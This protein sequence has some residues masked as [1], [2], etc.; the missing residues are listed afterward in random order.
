MFRTLTHLALA[1]ALIALTTLQALPLQ[2]QEAVFQ[3]IRLTETQITNYLK[4]QNELEKQLEKIE[5]A[6]RDP[7]PKLVQ[8]LENLAKKYGFASFE[9]LDSVVSNISFILA[10][11]DQDS[12]KFSEP[13]VAM[14]EEV[15]ALKRD[16]SMPARE[17]NALIQELEEAIKNTPNVQ[18]RENIT[19]VGK[20]RKQLDAALN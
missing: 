5:K 16:K 10:G 18:H 6:G 3:Q 11:F 19:L 14:A 4:A 12:G 13:R 9:E 1:V 7:D 20:Y 8:A 15:E 2:A 17:R